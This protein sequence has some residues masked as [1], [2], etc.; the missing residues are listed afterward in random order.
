MASKRKKYFTWP[1]TK[2]VQVLRKLLV[3]ME[4]RL[5]HLTAKITEDGI[6]VANDANFD[7]KEVKELSGQIIKLQEA[8]AIEERGFYKE[9]PPKA[10]VPVTQQENAA[11]AETENIVQVANISDEGN[12]LIKALPP[13]L[14]ASYAAELG[15]PY[16]DD[17]DDSPDAE[18]VSPVGESADSVADV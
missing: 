11:V 3:L 4:A 9:S 1:K 7:I 10:Q 8:L 5:D 14:R 13:A 15:I 17:D 6:F 18:R 16:S 12:I 2:R